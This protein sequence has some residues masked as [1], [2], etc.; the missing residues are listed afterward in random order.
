MQLVTR[1]RT[2]ILIGAGVI[3]FA[4]IVFL[5]VISPQGKKL[6]ALHAQESQLQSQQGRL[7][8]ELLA[9]KHDKADMA[10]NCASLNTALAEIPGAPD[11]SGFLQQVT[12]LAVATGNANTPTIS[13]TQASGGGTSSGATP[14]QVSLTLDGTYGQMAAFIKGLDSFPR[15]FTVTTISVAGGP[16]AQGGGTPS[17]STAGYSLNLTGAIYYSSGRVDSCSTST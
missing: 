10:T 16:I 15:L 8:T 11:V 6:S 13:V 3:V 4:V 2:P 9:L 12:A 17:P 14:V 1:F 5:G 7:E